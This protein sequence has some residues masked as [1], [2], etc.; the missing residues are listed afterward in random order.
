MNV[1]AVSQTSAADPVAERHPANSGSKVAIAK[2]SLASYDTT[3]RILKAWFGAYSLGVPAFLFT[4]DAVVHKLVAHHA[5]LCIASIFALAI[6][7][8]V[9]ILFFNKY[10]QWGVYAMHSTPERID[11]FT[12]WCDRASEWIW[13]DFWIDV[14]T[15]VLLAI[16]SVRVFFVVVAG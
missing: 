3:T 5:A 9:F 7:L 12:R 11:S 13:L 10:T 16:G 14:L 6:L 2:A 15:I 8:Q 1:S 4:R